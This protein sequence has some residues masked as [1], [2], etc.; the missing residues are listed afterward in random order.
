MTPEEITR[1]Q[2]IKTAIHSCPDGC[3][4]QV[5]GVPMLEEFLTLSIKEKDNK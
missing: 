1:L 3:A 5:L 2:E 4:I